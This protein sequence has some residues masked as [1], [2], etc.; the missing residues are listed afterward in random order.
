M[1]TFDTLEQNDL[2]PCIEKSFVLHCKQVE[3]PF[4]VKTPTGYVLGKAGDYIMTGFE[5]Y[6]NQLFICDGKFF[7]QTY[8]IL[9]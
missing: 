3:E 9:N 5:N 1:K 7:Q 2:V 4:R 8:D 6:G